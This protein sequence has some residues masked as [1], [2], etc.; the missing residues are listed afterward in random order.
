M[1]LNEALRLNEQKLIDDQQHI[2]QMAE[3]LVRDAIQTLE[4]DGQQVDRESV[5]DQANFFLNEVYESIVEQI[6]QQAA[7]QAE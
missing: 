5:E 6:K 3:Q 1:K 4:N 2:D 7:E